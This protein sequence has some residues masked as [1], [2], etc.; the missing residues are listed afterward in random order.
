VGG[1]GVEVGGTRVNVGVGGAGV[2]VGVEVGARVDVE[3]G[4]MIIGAWGRV[5]VGGRGVGVDVGTIT[6]C[7]GVGPGREGFPR[8]KLKDKAN[9]ANINITA[10]P[11][12]I[13][14]TALDRIEKE[15]T[16]F[17]IGRGLTRFTVGATSA[18]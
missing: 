10:T 18:R 17:L 15:G 11:A 9:N 1:T 13:P 3:E 16:G 14:I 4:V 5:G 6:I 2:G 7:A 8:I 12:A